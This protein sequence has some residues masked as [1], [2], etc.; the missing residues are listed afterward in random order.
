[1]KILIVGSW[2]PDK[3]K[4]YIDQANELGFELAKRGHILVASPSSGIQGL[5]AKSYKQN[6]GS[7]FIGYYPKLKLMEEV[8]EQVMIKPD[9]AIYTKQ[10][11]PIR[12]ILQV[13][14]SDAVIG[15]SG[16]IGTLTELIA[17]IKDYEI[18][19]A[20]YEDSSKLI[21]SF[22]KIEPDFANKLKYGTDISELINYLEQTK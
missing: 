7:E 22:R 13:K 19:T 11:Y 20:F 17:S 5:V 6:K 21:E 14:G 15:I 8:G 3:S 16:G 12:N 2:N 4:K 9:T 10:D 1:M 18:P